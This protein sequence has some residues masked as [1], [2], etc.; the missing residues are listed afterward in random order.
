[1]PGYWKKSE[2]LSTFWTGT[3]RR[4]TSDAKILF[5]YMI[6]QK[7][8]QGEVFGAWDHF[9]FHCGWEKEDDGGKATFETALASLMAPDPE[10]SSKLENGR[11]VIQIA[12]NHYRLVTHKEQEAK[13]AAERKRMRDRV[14]RKERYARETAPSSLAGSDKDKG[15][16]S[17]ASLLPL[18]G[19]DAAPPELVEAV[20][21]AYNNKDR[22]VTAQN[23][24]T[25]KYLTTSGP[26]GERKAHKPWV[27]L[28]VVEL[29]RADN[30]ARGDG[31]FCWSDQLNSFDA[32]I[33]RKAAYVED[34]DG[35]AHRT[36]K[37]Q[38]TKF[39]KMYI[40]FL[41]QLKTMAERRAAQEKEQS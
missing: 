23:V 15:A 25:W 3:M 16:A 18:P 22:A 27:I 14:G 34:D 29:A 33:T 11:R 4:E 21:I 28:A 40:H 24:K 41:P 32:L 1:M 2:I 13:L 30:L 12:P 19:G 7:D 26:T 38:P 39:E 5:L 8:R 31:A 36:T 10:S 6:D 37:G 9:A 35:K 17:Q 20:K